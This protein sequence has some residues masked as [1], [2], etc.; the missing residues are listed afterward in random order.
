MDYHELFSSTD[1]AITDAVNMVGTGNVTSAMLELTERHRIRSSRTIPR[2]ILPHHRERWVR[3]RIQ[4]GTGA[5]TNLVSDPSMCYEIW[6]QR[7]AVGGIGRGNSFTYY[8]SSSV[9]CRLQSRCG[10]TIV[11]APIKPFRVIPEAKEFLFNPKVLTQHLGFTST[12]GVNPENGVWEHVFKQNSTGF[13][14]LTSME[15]SGDEFIECEVLSR[16]NS[17]PETVRIERDSTSS[18]PTSSGEDLFRAELERRIDLLTAEQRLE[19]SKQTDIIARTPD[20]DKRLEQAFRMHCIG[21][22]RHSREL[23]DLCKRLGI[24]VDRTWGIWCTACL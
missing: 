5:Q 6:G 2:V 24:P 11:I 10:S 18:E 15:A 20:M 7:G 8:H 4:M 21:G 23:E 22:H 1:P 16:H 17:A 9:K 14:F 19:L 12:E 13:E 3:T